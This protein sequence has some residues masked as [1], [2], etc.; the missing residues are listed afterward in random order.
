ML[1]HS[2][3]PQ[4]QLS[5]LEEYVKQAHKFAASKWDITS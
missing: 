5:F 3:A 4:H 1:P 2:Q